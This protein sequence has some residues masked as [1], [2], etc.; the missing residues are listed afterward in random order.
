MDRDLFRPTAADKGEL[1]LNAESDGSNEEVLE[2]F[3]FVGKCIAKA[4]YDRQNLV[5]PMAPVFYKVIWG[6]P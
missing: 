4:I 6:W 3:K 1:E 2:K 5:L